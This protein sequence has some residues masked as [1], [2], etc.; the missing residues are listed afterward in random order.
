[1][2]ITNMTNMKMRRPTRIKISLRKSDPLLCAT[3][4]NCELICRKRDSYDGGP[5]EKRKCLINI[6]F[7]YVTSSP[8]GSVVSS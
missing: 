5:A 8:F 7:I 4:L 1:M 6:N 3:S 2:L